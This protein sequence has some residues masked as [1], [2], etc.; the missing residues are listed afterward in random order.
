[1]ITVAEA[2]G[3]HNESDFLRNVM[4][5]FHSCVIAHCVPKSKEL[6]MVVNFY[7]NLIRLG[8]EVPDEFLSLA[9]S[10]FQSFAKEIPSLFLILETNDGFNSTYRLL[11]HLNP[12]VSLRALQVLSDVCALPEDKFSIQMLKRGF[13]NWIT[14]PTLPQQLAHPLIFCLSNIVAD[15]NPEVLKI[16]IESNIYPNFLMPKLAQEL[17]TGFV[18]VDL[19]F[20]IGNAFLKADF[21]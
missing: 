13:L 12:Q 14:N 20:C 7:F 9:L 11:S 8:D 6:M 21:D 18:D 16:V 19:A 15:K 2:F 4:M 3:G 10:G 1:M 17:S 5:F